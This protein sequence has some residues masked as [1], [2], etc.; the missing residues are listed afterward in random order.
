MRNRIK[1]AKCGD[2]I[3]SLHRHDFKWCSCRSVAVDG[4]QDYQRVC[5]EFPENVIRILDDGTE[6]PDM[7]T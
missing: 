2:I 6:V 7:N 4:G 1:C 5:F 3:E